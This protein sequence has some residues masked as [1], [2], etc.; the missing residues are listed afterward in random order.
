MLAERR[1]QLEQF[2]GHTQLGGGGTRPGRGDL[3][4]LVDEQHQLVEFGEFGEGL[5]QR[6]RQPAGSDRR[7]PGRKQLDEGPAQP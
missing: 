3:L 2:V 6:G 5:S 1:D 7:Q 4:D